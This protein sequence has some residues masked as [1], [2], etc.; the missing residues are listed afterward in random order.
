MSTITETATER[1]AEL[2]AELEAVKAGLAENSQ[3]KDAAMAKAR[4]YA[5]EW[6]PERSRLVKELVTARRDEREEA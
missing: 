1:V 6:Q 2:E 3:E 5:A 4:K